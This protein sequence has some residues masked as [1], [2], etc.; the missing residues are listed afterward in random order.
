M[1]LPDSQPWDTL[2]GHYS[3]E[4]LL[5]PMAA[6]KEEGYTSLGSLEEI[7]TEFQ[8]TEKI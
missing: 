7:Q 3:E 6:S 2:P 8:A 1:V 4:S 5:S